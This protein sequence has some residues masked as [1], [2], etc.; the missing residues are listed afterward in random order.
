[1][2]G[3]EMLRIADFDMMEVLVDVNENDIIRISKGDTADI[4]VDAIP[5][6]SSRAW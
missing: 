1:M 4:E 2:A 5:A 6:G 3:T